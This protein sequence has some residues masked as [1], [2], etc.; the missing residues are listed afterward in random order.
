MLSI[1]NFPYTANRQKI[2]EFFDGK[3]IISKLIMR[4]D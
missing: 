3:A 4:F 2:G 1:K